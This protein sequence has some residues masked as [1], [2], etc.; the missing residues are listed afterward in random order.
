[1]KHIQ[2]AIHVGARGR[3]LDDGYSYKREHIMWDDDDS[4]HNVSHDDKTPDDGYAHKMMMRQMLK[5]EKLTKALRKAVQKNDQKSVNDILQS[6]DMDIDT[7]LNKKGQA[8]LSLAVPHPEMVK[9]LLKNEAIV[10][11]QD[12]DEETPLWQASK[13]GNNESVELLIEAGANVNLAAQEEA[14]ILVSI[15]NKTPDVLQS[16]ISARADV[17]KANEHGETALILATADEKTDFMQILMNAGADALH[18]TKN[19]HSAFEFAD[20]AITKATRK[21]QDADIWDKATQKLQD[22]DKWDLAFKSYEEMQ[23]MVDI[24]TRRKGIDSRKIFD[25]TLRPYRQAKIQE[26]KYK[27][28]WN[29]SRKRL[30]ELEK[31]QKF[32]DPFG[33]IQKNPKRDACSMQYFGVQTCEGNCWAYA[34]LG[35]VVKFLQN[36][37][38]LYEA[39][40][41]LVKYQELLASELPVY[42][43]NLISRG[44]NRG[45]SHDVWNT[46]DTLFDFATIP[47]FP[48]HKN[49][50]SKVQR[51]PVSYKNTTDRPGTGEILLISILLH[52]G[53][54]VTLRGFKY[55][56]LSK[57]KV[58]KEEKH[59]VDRKLRFR[60]G[61]IQQTAAS[62]VQEFLGKYTKEYLMIRVKVTFPTNSYSRLYSN[63]TKTSVAGSDWSF[64]SWEYTFQKKATCSGLIQQMI[65][66]ICKQ[67]LQHRL[68]GALLTY[69]PTP[70]KSNKPNHE[71]LLGFCNG[72]AFICN[73]H[74]GRCKDQSADIDRLL[75]DDCIVDQH[76]ILT[77]VF[78]PD[79]VKYDGKFK[80]GG[81]YQTNPSTLSVPGFVRLFADDKCPGDIELNADAIPYVKSEFIKRANSTQEMHEHITKGITDIKTVHGDAVLNGLKIYIFEVLEGEG[82]MKTYEFKHRLGSKAL[83]IGGG[84]HDAMAILVPSDPQ[85]VLIVEV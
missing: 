82:D 25:H 71:I 17:N 75:K 2:S 37:T 38:K 13:M 42:N 63:S 6:S 76:M 60:E 4:A 56:G 31:I 57:V 20:G 7:P 72:V 39:H 80:P 34:A 65:L 11:I 48:Y 14:P 77:Y 61:K 67:G 35:M 64:L 84:L 74:D 79:H 3:R 30:K 10:D 66:E 9:F 23:K 49:F 78:S 12:S 73:S 46:Y 70:E 51:G 45:L 26:R 58:N 40:P 69:T 16:L 21:L 5:F 83:T 41:R 53:Y 52:A 1:M 36:D 15:Q 85:K 29:T 54:R 32:R 44:T 68:C 43:A 55:L 47:N 19:G 24:L 8:A 18:K 22:A 62:T 28:E 59:V 81:L 27:K 50:P 33:E